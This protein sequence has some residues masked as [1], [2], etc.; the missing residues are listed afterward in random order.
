MSPGSTRCSGFQEA[1]RPGGVVFDLPIAGVQ[2]TDGL[3]QEKTAQFNQQIGLLSSALE[4][5]TPEQMFSTE[6]EPA[7]AISAVKA[8]SKANAEGQRIYQMTRDNMASTLPNLNLATETESEI[9]TALNAGLTVIAHTDNVSVPGWTGAGYIIFNPNTGDGAYK[10][11]GGQNGGFSCGEACQTVGLVIALIAAS[12]ALVA[13]VSALIAGSIIFIAAF[14]G[15]ALTL[16]GIALL[17][18]K[19]IEIWD[20]CSE[21]FT[22][23]ATIIAVISAEFAFLLADNF[24]QL[25]ALLFSNALEFSLPEPEFNC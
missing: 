3:E 6:A 24:Q 23:I 25:L 1:Y 16:I 19:I 10:I 5:A 8:L 4:H 2:L 12:A 17:I 11:S 21:S 13:L 15:A 18:P 9:R 22:A 14:P 7:D 20:E